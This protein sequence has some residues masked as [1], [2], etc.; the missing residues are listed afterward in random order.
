LGAEGAAVTVDAPQG[1]VADPNDDDEIIRECMAR[2]LIAQKAE[3]ANRQEAL[4]DKRFINGD[5]WETPVRN[6]RTLNDKP[7]LTINITAAVRNRIV[8][9]CRENRPRIKVH[10]VGDG[11]DVQS[12]NL[13]DGLIRHIETASS[14]DHAYDQAVEN[15]IDAGWG[16][17][18]ID[19]DYERPD[20]FDQE[21]AVVGFANPFTCYM[22]PASVQPDGCD[23]RWF[24][25]TTMLARQEYRQRWGHIDTNGW[26]YHSAGD[27]LSN[28]SNKEQIR[29]AKYWRIEYRRDTLYRLSAGPLR[30]GKD[31]L[32]EQGMRAAGL[33]IIDKRETQIPTVCC[34]MLTAYTVLERRELPGRYIP[35]VPVYGR[36]QDIDGKVHLK[37]IVR[38]LRDPARLFNYAESAKTETYAL[39]P[40]APWLTAEG[41]LDGHEPAWRDANR[42]AIV[43][44]PYKPV[45]LD[46]G[47]YA[48][49]PLRQEPPQPAAG[50]AEWCESAKTNFFAVAGMPHDPN[51]D[52]KGEVVSGVAL[53]R[54]QGISDISHYDFYDNLTRSLRH[55]GRI[56][57]GL[58]PSYYD[59]PR[60]MRI[61]REDGTPEQV[62]INQKTAE[63]IKNDMTVG[64]YEVVVDTG[65]SYQT[66]REESAE[67]MIELLATPLGEMVAHTCG[68][69][70]VRALDFPMS[71]SMADRLMAAIPAAQMDQHSDLP[72]K[73][74]ALIAGLQA[75]L[76]QQNQKN[77][78]LELELHSKAGI[79]QMR[80]QGEDRRLAFKE[81]AETQRAHIKAG[82][83]MHDTHVKAVTAHDVAEI[84]AGGD[85]LK[86][87]VEAEHER[88]LAKETAAA[89][90]SAERRSE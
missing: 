23:M 55:L 66:K 72:P 2:F 89:A 43:A 14:A 36:R 70:I 40:K 77:M 79:E 90:E 7:C 47:T 17:L 67:A 50:F 62:A 48:P 60:M 19:G 29:I 82:T 58:I 18:G 3:S 41:A 65:P 73:A 46:D 64:R 32:S 34:Y 33:S 27:N 26:Q 53:R 45:K 69:Q 6:D 71:D 13:Y 61:V 24:I 38:D 12:A 4:Y 84:Q 15:A 22:D 20:S 51:V 25:E 42:K 63:K 81:K 16:Y 49:P 52:L 44:L 56:M 74:Q 39:Q 75:Q 54:R 68:D 59:T 11:A 57:V 10:P 5:Q 21:L 76:K 83:A 85:L 80:Q 87:H 28:W 1:K 88:R 37:G 8:N 9:A 30:L 31:M 35:R 86:T 78:A